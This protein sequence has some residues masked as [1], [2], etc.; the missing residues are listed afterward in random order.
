MSEQ[1]I[2][3]RELL[4]QAG[5]VGAG[6]VVAGSLTGKAGAALGKAAMHSA[7]P[8]R[9]GRITWA[10]EQDPGHIAPYGA[11]LTITRTA[12]EPMYESLLEWD[13]DLNV[14]PAISSSY[15]IKDARTIDFNIR[16]GI[17]FSNGQDVTADDVKYSFDLQLAP[18][19][20]GSVS[21]L[22]QVPSIAGIEVLSKSKVRMHLKSAD[23][24]VLGYLAWQRYSAI[25]P[26]GMYDK[27][28]PATQGIGTGPYMLDGSYVPNDH[29]NYV[30]NPNYWKKG[31]PYLDAITYKIITD[32]QA[33][34]AAL[35]AGAID[36]ATVSVDSA[37]ALKSVSGLKVLHNLTAAF[38]ELQFTIKDGEN[39]PWADRRVRQAIN[40]AINRQ[41][42][43]NKVY[44]GTGQYTGHVAAGYGPWGIPQKE[45]RNKWEKY[46]LPKAK[47]LMKAA[48]FAKGFDINLS[49]FST[50]LDFPAMAA[51]IQ[52][53]LKLI[54]INV[55]IVAQDPATFA[56]NNGRGAF[57]MDLTA[58]GMRGDVDGY[59]AE[60]N[61]TGAF[62]KTVYNTWFSGYTNKEMWRL[63]GNGRIT[64]DPKKRL[65]MYQKLDRLLM[66]ELLEVPLVSVSKYQVVNAKLQDM[67][68]A[69]TDFNTGLRTAWLS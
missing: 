44:N 13:K 20:P 69:F 22:G 19:L 34:I 1:G 67:Y 5:A 16:P 68:V 39:K 33:R 57:E 47:A 28:N 32:E 2:S 26:N 48:G 63:V 9:G 55:N 6:A 52:S 40:F 15:V 54:N 23:A 53:Y 51:L 7:T 46:D 56:A 45:L 43:L 30:R 42:I 21:V 31:Q 58:R 11:I 29:L 65:P 3:R 18:P 24:R 4:K 17:K 64:L 36:G 41:D 14:H 37:N 8:K 59:T 50:P 38:R 49:T 12:Q 62:G 25:V 66:T 10:L 60:F 35:R 27:L 61:P